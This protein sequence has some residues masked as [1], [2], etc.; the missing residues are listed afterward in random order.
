M[1]GQLF[2]TNFLLRGTTELPVWRGVESD[3]FAAFRAELARIFAS[4]TAQSELNEAQ[5]EDEIVKP[6]LTAPGFADAWLSQAN[7]SKTR[8]E[9]VPDYLIFADAQRK[10]D[11]LTRSEGHRPTLGLADVMQA[12]N[13]ESRGRNGRAECRVGTHRYMEKK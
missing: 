10:A 8:R 3:G 12:L 7:I 4:R 1:Q 2:T 13:V 11:A 5:T 9:D 6:I